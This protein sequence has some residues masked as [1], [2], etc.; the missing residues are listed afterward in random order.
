MAAPRTCACRCRLP[1]A[2]GTPGGASRAAPRAAPRELHRARGGGGGESGSNGG[3][4]TQ[5]K[6]TGLWWWMQRTP[7]Q[8]DTEAVAARKEEPREDEVTVR[9]IWRRN[10]KPW[11]PGEGRKRGIILLE[12]R[13][14]CKG[15]GK[16][17]TCTRNRHAF[18]P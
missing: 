1:R 12:K 14:N 2:C 16:V 7:G 13:T 11:K 9:E 3:H 6:K 15:F 5:G 8:E 10:R 17:V 18:K 4:G